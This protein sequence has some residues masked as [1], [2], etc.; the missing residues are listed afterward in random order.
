M[1][2]A[3]VPRPSQRPGNGAATRPTQCASKR[4]TKRGHMKLHRPS[5]PLLIAC[6]ALFLAAGGPASAVNAA[7]AASKLL[8]GKQIKDNSISSKDV[9]NGTLV[10]KDFKPG[11]L[12]KIVAASQGQAGG[13]G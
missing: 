7:D 9:K 6:L 2:V 1:V 5:V 13:Q 10:A 8:T 11:V 3:A 12:P 4:T